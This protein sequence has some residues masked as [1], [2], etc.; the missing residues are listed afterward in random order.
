MNKDLDL[1]E[2]KKIV[3]FMAESGVLAFELGE[4]KVS[5]DPM[6]VK[7][8]KGQGK[9]LPSEDVMQKDLSTQ[10]H[11]FS[12]KQAAMGLSPEEDDIENWSL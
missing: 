1:S 12:A 2:I 9:E 6:R 3:K 10:L 5:F 4:F 7:L 11:E 8:R